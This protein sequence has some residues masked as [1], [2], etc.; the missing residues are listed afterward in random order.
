[1]HDKHMIQRLK[2]GVY[3]FPREHRG[4]A[5]AAGRRATTTGDFTAAVDAYLL[6][7]Q[8][9]DESA[10]GAVPHPQGIDAHR[11]TVASWT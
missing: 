4:H 10:Q 1:M 8:L 7:E 5:L 6:E 9:A 11:L 2:A 3:Q